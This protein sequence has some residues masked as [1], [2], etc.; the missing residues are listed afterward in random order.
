M[1]HRRNEALETACRQC[2]FDR[3][4]T[5][6]RVYRRAARRYRR[7]IPALAG[8]CGRDSLARVLLENPEPAT[9]WN[10]IRFLCRT[11]RRIRCVRTIHG[12]YRHPQ[13]IRAL[14]ELIL[15][16]IHLMA[17]QRA[18]AARM[19]GEGAAAVDEAAE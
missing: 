10:I 17:R 14:E 1:R 4:R 13:K 16:E 6:R 18:T 8:W 5:L 11:L 9:T 2:A 19:I 15:C 12:T 7:N 3:R